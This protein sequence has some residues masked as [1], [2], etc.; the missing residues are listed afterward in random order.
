ME[1][2]FRKSPVFPHAPF[3]FIC[4]YP[5]KKWEEIRPYLGWTFDGCEPSDVI[6]DSRALDCQ[7]EE[8]RI[9]DFRI[10]LARLTDQPSKHYEIIPSNCP[11][12]QMSLLTKPIAADI[13][14]EMVEKCL[15]LIRSDLR[16][17]ANR[18]FDWATSRM[19]PRANQ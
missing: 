2:P 1:I 16:A 10:S 14:K 3:L 4:F 12:D 17:F 11:L 13:A 7:G 5:G 18:Y 15:L 9:R 6:T 8:F 19:E